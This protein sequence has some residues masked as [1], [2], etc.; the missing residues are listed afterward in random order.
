M[1]FKAFVFFAIVRLSVLRASASQVGKGHDQGRSQ[2]HH[3]CSWLQVALVMAPRRPAPTPQLWKKVSTCKVFESYVV[4][5]TSCGL[6]QIAHTS[7]SYAL[8]DEKRARI[9]SSLRW[10]SD[11]CEASQL[12]MKPPMEQRRDPR[13]GWVCCYDDVLSDFQA[14]CILVLL[15]ATRSMHIEAVDDVN[16]RIS[17]VVMGVY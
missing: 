15:H 16:L 3:R 6:S 17:C 1:I 7:P 5:W 14:S 2:Q 11:T 9:C 4:M 13:S 8:C 10:W 12:T